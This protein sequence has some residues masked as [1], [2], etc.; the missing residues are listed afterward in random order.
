MTSLK[1]NKAENTK[2]A[3]GKAFG[4]DM[5]AYLKAS[6][7]GTECIFFSYNCYMKGM[8]V[9]IGGMILTLKGFM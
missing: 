8:L 1:S 3:L 5:Y 4:V 6:I 7:K 9:Y 2:G